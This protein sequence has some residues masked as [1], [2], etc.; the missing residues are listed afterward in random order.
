MSFGF[1]VTDF[2]TLTSLAWNVYKDCKSAS[3]EFREVG[4]EVISLHTSLRELQDECEDKDSIL[5]SN[6][7]DKKRTLNVLVQNCIEV[8]KELQ[9]LL[10][11]YRSLGTNQK[12]AWDRVK[13]GSEGIQEIRNKLMFHTSSLTLFL[14]TLET[15]SLRRMEKKI[16]DLAAQIRAGCHEPSIVSLCDDADVLEQENSWRLL[17]NELSDDFSMDEIQKHKD[18]IKL[19]IRELV[20]RGDFEE[21]EPGPSLGTRGDSTAYPTRLDGA[22]GDP[23]PL[24]GPS[25]GSVTLPIR[26]PPQPSME[27]DS[28]STCSSPTGKPSN[29]AAFSQHVNDQPNNGQ[30]DKSNRTS[31]SDRST[32]VETSSTGK[33]TINTIEDLFP[34]FKPA[35]HVSRNLGYVGIELGFGCGRVAAY[36]SELGDAVVL[37][38]EHG[39]RSTPAYVAFTHDNILVGEDAKNQASRNIENTFSGFTLLLGSRFT[40][41]ITS[42]L[43]ENSCFRISNIEGKPA[44]FAPCRQ[45]YYS[46]EELTAFLL[47]K[48]VRVAEVTLGDIISRIFL[49]SQSARHIPVMEALHNAAL[50]ANVVL[51]TREISTAALYNYTRQQLRNRKEESTLVLVISARV[52]GCECTLYE[53]DSGV[54]DWK[55]TAAHFHEKLSVDNHIGTL[56][57]SNFYANNPEISE[58]LS[59]RGLIRLGRAAEDARRQLMSADKV[60]IYLDSFHEGSELAVRVFQTQLKN[61][62][63]ESLIPSIRDCLEQLVRYEKD[64]KVNISEVILL[65]ELINLPGLRDRLLQLSK[66]VS[67]SNGLV[68]VIRQIDPLEFPVLGIALDHVDVHSEK[69][70]QI[71]IVEALRSNFLL[72]SVNPEN[73]STNMYLMHSYH[74]HIPTYKKAELLTTHPDQKGALLQ[75]FTTERHDAEAPRIFFE[76]AFLL[77]SQ[78][79]P[80]TTRK[81]ALTLNINVNESV[82]LEIIVHDPPSKGVVLQLDRSAAGLLTIQRGSCV[83][84]TP[85]VRKSWRVLCQKPEKTTSARFAESERLSKSEKPAKPAR[86]PARSSEAERLAESAR[87]FAESE[88][89]A[90]S[91]RPVDSAKSARRFARSA[92]SARPAEYK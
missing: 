88:R 35:E 10:T 18:E 45:K 54:I 78:L 3:A 55:W 48:L 53:S 72:A 20:D 51:R 5:N 34:P 52:D 42:I 75:F 92:K 62:V 70:S 71:L 82:F 91:E 89:L 11:R 17:L 49:A 50:L 23:N 14:T 24:N 29:L 2:L 63:D 33:R 6:Q 60:D 22:F 7:E 68:T 87:S 90:K 43:A 8:L 37:S 59:G 39:N 16:D 32:L 27:S 79:K 46:P 25:I 40:D 19:Y 47:K 9:Q 66:D 44:F 56:L 76:I 67:V 12:R 74:D 28:E 69:G 86:R 61:A 73:A 15:T 4:N 81:F 21:H 65:G 58:S 84:I 1:G 85:D 80:E 38:N 13:F 64:K 30:V 41:K 57:R 77:P 83:P 31:L 36:D 26:Y